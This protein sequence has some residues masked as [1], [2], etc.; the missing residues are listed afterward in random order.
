MASHITIGDVSPRIQYT[1]D[2]VQA[3]FTYPFPI[4]ENVDLEVYADA[5]LQSTGYTISGAGD[6]AGGLVTFDTAPV[7]GVIV[8]LAR[9]LNIQRTSDFQESGEF[10]SKVINDELDYLTASLQQVSD[11][12]SRS[13]QMSITESKSVDTTLPTPV[14]NMSIV[15]N[16]MGAG[17]TN[18]PTIDEIANAQLYATSAS[19]SSVAA[20]TAAGQ[21]ATSES[22][23]AT[24]AATAL[25]ATVG[26]YDVRVS[27]TSADSP[28][29]VSAMT[30]DTLLN[31]DTTGG[32]VVVNLPPA[33]GEADNRLLGINK[34]GAANTVTIMANG[35]DTIG[36]AAS[37][38]QYDD[39]E[40][41]DL[42]LDKTATDWL[43][44]NLS[45]TAAG[46]GLTKTGSTI[47]LD[48]TSA[49]T[50]TAPQLAPT[51]TDND[52]TFDMSA[53]TDFICTPTGAITVQF[54]GETLGQRGMVRLDNSG[55]HV[56]TMGAE[57]KSDVD[58]VTSL[59][60]AG[61]Y[62]LGYWCYD[63]VNVDLT[64]STARA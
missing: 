21:A 6:S 2:G 30:Q 3:A 62:T 50:W 15:W 27:I 25:A 16:N 37:F 46:T 43:L 18:G 42:Y 1:A 58:A 10:R 9:R 38:M 59:S 40:W 24:S 8:T 52:G 35:A 39:T 64:Y 5:A 54:T 56:I 31:V 48:I 4:F 11:D 34:I 45:F 26:K 41:A 53:K 51:L 13:L 32:A 57:V 20:A 44:G 22:N 47:A 23:A 36:G 7:S 19:A 28:Y 33:S 60:T 17:I 55:G 61:I 63:G 12:Q 14:A 49:N 29:T